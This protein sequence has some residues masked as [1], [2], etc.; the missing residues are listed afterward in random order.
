MTSKVGNLRH[1]SRIGRAFSSRNYRLYFAGQGLS[2]IGTWMTLIATNWLVLQLTHSAWWLGIV[3]FASQIPTFCLAPFAGVFVDRWSR[4]HIVVAAQVLAMFQSLAL[5]F[6]ALTGMINIWQIIGLSL[7][8][9]LI[10]AVSVP[11]LQA[12]V[13]EI[14]EKQENL[15]NAIALNASL[16]SSARLIGPAIGGLLIATVGSGMC[17]LIDGISYIAVLV[18]L[19]SM[20]LPPVKISVESS[21][22]WQRLKTGFSY[23][24]GFPPIRSVLLLMALLGFMGLPY[25]VLA[26][27]F[28]TD[29]LHGGAETLGFLMAASAL[30][31][32]IASI[33]LSSRLSVVGLENVIAMAPRIWGI[34]FIVFSL[35]RILGF[36]LIVMVAVGFGVVLQIAA[37][38]TFVQTI[39]EDDKRGRVMSF[40]SM[41][42]M[43]MVP[44][45]SLF[46]GWLANQIGAPNTLIINGAV[47]IF[48]SFIFAK[49]LPVLTSLIQPIYTEIGILPKVHS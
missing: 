22:Q 25:V 34:G 27:I 42:F 36:S 5:A 40:F 17:F 15:G 28:A 4:Y 32:F 33:Y 48:S 8:Q 11:A 2:M 47:C 38:N 19:M 13:K 29:V 9:G 24:F 14:V 23:A 41:S 7:L 1:L 44:F 18:A 31:A 46:S 37:C 21:P 45:G 10:N 39:V 6:L 49:Y 35:S 20:K 12:F 26:P 3:G 16:I 43:G 30:G